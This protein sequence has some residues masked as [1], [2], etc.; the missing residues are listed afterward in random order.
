MKRIFPVDFVPTKT[1]MIGEF[2][3]GILRRLRGATEKRRG[4]TRQR[5][6]LHENAHA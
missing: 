4:G 2:Y 5:V 3:K 6:F 1:T